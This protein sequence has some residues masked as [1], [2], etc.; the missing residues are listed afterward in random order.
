MHTIEEYSETRYAAIDYLGKALK[1]IPLR[2][3]IY[4]LAEHGS[5]L[6]DS[7]HCPEA[8]AGVAL[9]KTYA[10]IELLGE[11]VRILRQKVKLA[12]ARVDKIEA[13]NT[14]IDDTIAYFMETS[15]RGRKSNRKNGDIGRLQTKRTVN[16]EEIRKLEE[17]YNPILLPVSP[18]I[19]TKMVTEGGMFTGF[20]DEVFKVSAVT[21]HDVF[22]LHPQME[23]IL[24]EYHING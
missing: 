3:K 20:A 13:D 21:V 22:L 17:E 23:G 14:S 15:H 16:N 5:E 4:H 6:L 7:D 1:G 12:L 11:A 10:K 8:P 18:M 9:L 2:R 19:V 24:D